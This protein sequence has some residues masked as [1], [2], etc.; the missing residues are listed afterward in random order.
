MAS[1]TVYILQTWVAGRG[2]ALTAGPQ[3][4]CRDAEEARRKAGRLA[5]LRLGVV[6]FSV[7]ADTE[8]GDYDE[9]P[10]L[11]FRAGQL[12]EIFD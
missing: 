9:T 1:E 7:S 10:A 12:P 5:P 2:G 11:L 4:G 6:A 8:P 3:V